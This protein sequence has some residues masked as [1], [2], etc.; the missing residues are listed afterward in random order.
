MQHWPSEVNNLKNLESLIL[1]SNRIENVDLPRASKT[2][3]FPL[4]KLKILKLNMNSIE[5]FPVQILVLSSL[6]ELD[7]SENQL[8]VI[9]SNLCESMPKLKV[10]KQLAGIFNNC[11]QIFTGNM[12]KIEEFNL[13]NAASALVSIKI[14]AN[15]LK[16]LSFN[17]SLNHVTELCLSSCSLT[18]LPSALWY[19]CCSAKITRFIVK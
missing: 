16:A 10:C 9:P 15:S 12:S 1:F 8:G 19:C 5:A 17:S 6:E 14:S 2:G 7:L 13:S 11:L 4:Q 3:P 18:E